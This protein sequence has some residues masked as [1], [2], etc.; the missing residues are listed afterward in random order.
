VIHHV[1]YV[2]SD[3]RAGVERFAALTGAGPFYAMEHIEFD[4]VTYEGAPARYDHS[5][6]FAAWGPILIE[7]TQVHD[8]QPAGLRD[9]LT[10]PG[11]GTGH[12]AWLADDLEAETERLRRA[13]LE[14]FHTGRAGPASAVWFHGGPAFG[15]P[16]EVL[17]RRDE[18][19]GFYA[20][21]REAAEGWD[22]SAPLRVMS[23]P[24]A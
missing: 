12:V 2:V 10:V 9:A 17:Q 13:G 21:V 5:S 19:L 23:G 6:A 24:P 15:H 8:A 18:I 4:E 11:G 3:L 1:G 14:P 20:M 16:V 22:G 7:L